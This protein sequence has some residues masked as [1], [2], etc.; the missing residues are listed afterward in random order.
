M[1]TTSAAYPIQV[2]FMNSSV[3]YYRWPIE[4]WHTVVSF[5]PVNVGTDLTEGGSNVED[6]S[7]VSWLNGIGEGDVVEAR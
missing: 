1:S 5:P 4:F 3:R 7:F 2:M 6:V